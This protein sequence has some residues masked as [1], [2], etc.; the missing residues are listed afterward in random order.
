MYELPKFLCVKPDIRKALDQGQAVVALESTIIAHGMPYPQNLETAQGLESIIREQ[1]ALPATI[2]ILD[3]EMKVGLN[4]DEL[5][6]LA[7]S[8]DVLK[9]SRRDLSYTLALGLPGACTVAATMMIAHW[10]GIKVFATGGIG[11]VH[12]GASESMDISA[13]LKELGSTPVAVV[14]AG[15]KAILDIGLT[16]EYLETEGVPVLG[17]QCEEF[18]AF[19]SRQSG[20]KVG[21]KIDSVED[22][23]KILQTHQR[24]QLK[25]G[26]LIANPI[27]E[28]YEM[29]YQEM[30]EAIQQAILEADQK[31]IK[32]K[33]L[34]PFLLQRIKEITQG[35]SLEANI[36]LVSNNAHLAARIARALSELD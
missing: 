9:V 15:A 23:A 30:Q 2:A 34:T 3:G 33:E 18:P 28:K 31:E 21:R 10:A 17:Y 14:S 24:L 12:R 4:P 29:A 13:D 36:E 35:Q 27:P 20:F 1:G 11:G 5:E 22:L 6:R 25:S 7:R 19:Y 8:S 26:I 16:L 32:G